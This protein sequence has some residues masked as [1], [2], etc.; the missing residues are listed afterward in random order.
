MEAY[1]LASNAKLRFQTSRGV[2][3]VEQLW[4]LS[5]EDLDS[6][7]VSLEAAHKESG[8]KSFL[9]KTSVKDKMAKLAFDVALDILNSKVE[10]N[11]AALEAI[12]TKQ[13]NE[14]I[15]NL[16]AEKQDDNLRGLSIA[17]LKAKLK[18]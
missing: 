15:L 8:K 5:L 2:L 12:E 4:D 9:N 7:A 11:E 16:I 1:K 14:K 17:Q 18:K 10:D 6:L 3:S 13:F